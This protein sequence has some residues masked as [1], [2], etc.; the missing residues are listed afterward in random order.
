MI[1]NLILLSIL[2]SLPARGNELDDYFAQET[3]KLEAHCLSE[4][5]TKEDWLEK[6]KGY[7]RQLQEMLGLDPWPER[8]DLKAVVTGTA[9]HDEFSVEKL[10]FQSMP[11]LYVTGNLY[12]PKGLAGPVPG[13]LYV[14]GHGR[15]VAD[16]VSLGNKAHY[17]HHGAWFARHGYA[18]LT[19]DT[20]QLGEIEGIHHGTYRENMWWWN[21]RGYTP[22]GVEAWNGIRALDYLQSR[23]EIDG[24]K[25]GVTG[26]SGGGIYSWWVGA[27]DDR[28][29]VAVPV[30]GITS[31]RNHVVD[32]CVEGHCDCMYH[33]NTYR[34][35]FPQI[36]ALMAPRPLLISNSD[37]D[38]IFPL[39]GVYAVHQKVKRIY[40]LLDAEENLGLQITEGPHKDTQELRIHAFHWFNRFLKGETPLIREVAEPLMDPKALR[41]FTA[42]PDDERTSVIH[43]TFVP[44]ASPPEV[45][46]D[47]A[48]WESLRDR[49]MNLLE[50]K[51][52]AG[53]PEP[54]EVSSLPALVELAPVEG[55]EGAVTLRLIDETKWARDPAK[56]HQLRRRFMLL[57]Q[58]LDGMRVWDLLRQLKEREKPVTIH[59]EGRAAGIALYASLFTGSKQIAG[60]SLDKLPVSH[61]EGPIF[62]NVSKY[63]D[64][65]ATVTMAAERCPVRVTGLTE[66]ERG[67]LDFSKETL[68]MLGLPE[69]LAFR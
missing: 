47:R 22:A 14:C 18:C 48:A 35:D 28:I 33:I 37:K 3:G 52:F 53:W 39:D 43:E 55:E 62:L 1:R 57:G 58:T 49:W 65:P 66:G 56:A 69:R 17:Q 20:I 29:K 7:R 25:L 12:L 59:A 5:Q 60:L 38:T 31:L 42:L 23:P 6:R 45:P 9:D 27:L 67:K 40:A 32:G 16:G 46:P 15:V 54:D 63:L 13:I 41:V 51:V 2:L 26:R 30:A 4:I 36:A 19:I 10:H 11:G 44:Q 24:E 8:T 50:A 64:I 61:R 68:A 34:W 21:N